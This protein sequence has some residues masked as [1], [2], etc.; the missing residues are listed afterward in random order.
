MIY[1]SISVIPQRV[2]NLNESINSLLNQT[3][4]PD[5][6]FINIPYKYKRFTETIPDNQIP[7][8]NSDIIE[9]TRCDDYGPGT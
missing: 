6:I 7:N 9:V 2:K 4:K 5:K 1:I 3:L 8:F